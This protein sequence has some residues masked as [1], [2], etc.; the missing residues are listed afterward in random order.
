MTKLNDSY[1]GAL[2]RFKNS[3]FK[4][5]DYHCQNRVHRDN[6]QFTPSFSGLA[7]WIIAL[8]KKYVPFKRTRLKSFD[9]LKEK[10]T[11]IRLL[12]YADLNK[13]MVLYIDE[14]NLCI[15]AWFTQS[16]PERGVYQ[17]WYPCTS[18]FT[19]TPPLIKGGQWMRPM[20]K[21]ML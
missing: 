18:C 8:T 4:M 9:T 14:S 11:T 10:L 1:F 21:C 3:L 16:Y 5:F 20:L 2:K 12:A 19:G 17:R 7:T 6:R 15:E 13:S